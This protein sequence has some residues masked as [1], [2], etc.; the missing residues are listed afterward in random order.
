M[1]D[2]LTHRSCG[3]IPSEGHC[4]IVSKSSVGQQERKELTSRVHRQQCQVSHNNTHRDHIVSFET[5]KLYSNHFIQEELT[6]TLSWSETDSANM[7]LCSSMRSV[8]FLS[9]CSAFRSSFNISFSLA[10]ARRAMN[11]LCSSSFV[12]SSCRFI[13]CSHSSVNYRGVMRFRFGAGVRG[14]WGTV[15]FRFKFWGSPFTSAAG[16][17]LACL[18]SPILI[19]GRIITFPTGSRMVFCIVSFLSAFNGFNRSVWVNG[20]P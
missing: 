7:S 19:F 20:A 11:L 14:F 13:D 2:K 18:T 9:F 12:P 15:I 5:N 3:T 6:T 16:S 8:N 4:S 17:F 1:G 10:S